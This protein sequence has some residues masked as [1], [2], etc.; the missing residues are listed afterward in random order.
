MSFGLFVFEKKKEFKT[1]MDI[2]HYLDEFSEYKEDRDYN[3][4]EGCSKSIEAWVRGM[5]EKFPP[6]NSEYAPPDDVAFASSESEE[7][8]S[9]YSIGQEAVYCTF[10]WNVA[11]E[12]LAH[13]LDLSKKLG[14]S[15]MDPQGEQ[16]LFYSDVQ[17]LVFR[18]E[19]K[20][21][22]FAYWEN[23]EEEIAT[24]DSVERGT[25]NRENA[26][27]TVWFTKESQPELENEYIQCTPNYKKKSLKSLFSS[28]K[29]SNIDGYDF[30]VMKHKVLYQTRLSNKEELL[31]MFRLWCIERKEIDV[32][33]YEKIME[34]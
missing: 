15:L 1:S 25:S 12:A 13:A 28:K 19:G 32:S 9:D 31:E 29:E 30:E 34:L 17:I 24:L 21:D 23:I 27:L 26:F 6:M 18:T 3:S 8:L 33:G 2:L 10:S 5:F 7:Y 20:N 16:V 4:L 14:L 22:R 11:E